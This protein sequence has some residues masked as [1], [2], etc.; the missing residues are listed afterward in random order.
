MSNC[1]RIKQALLGL[2]PSLM[3]TADVVAFE[4]ELEG[5]ASIIAGQVIED[6]RAPGS[7]S[8]PNTIL[9]HTDDVSFTPDSLFAVQLFSDVQDGLTATAQAVAR[10]EEDWEPSLVWGFLTY[11]LHDNV[12][13]KM[14]RSRAPFFL[15]SDTIDVGY[16]YP[17][18]NPPT[19]VYILSGIDNYD[20]IN[21]E[22]SNELASWASRVNLVAGNSA[23]QIRI[24]GRETDIE[25]KQIQSITWNLNRDWFTLQM[26]LAQTDATVDAY[27]QL[28]GAFELLQIPLNEAELDLLTLTDDV[29]TFAGIGV[30]IDQHPWLWVSEYTAIEI[31]DAPMQHDRSAWYS[32]VGYRWQK[33]TS[34]VTY[35]VAK[36]PVA[37]G[38]RAFVNDRIMTRLDLLPTDN[39][40]AMQLI[41][42][43]QLAY[44]TDEHLESIG[45][46]FRYE[47]HRAAAFK[48]EIQHRNNKISDTHPTVM[49]MGIDMVF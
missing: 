48:T 49:L 17:W 8:N 24:G 1:R 23:T 20:G 41:E 14:G 19:D 6:E 13:V 30:Y 2:L 38:T 27:D 26:S 45:L 18:I 37:E 25:C 35:G 21:I 47:F 9:G 7:N 4:A 42:T 34:H 31:E 11:Q 5:F 3:A 39:A 44:L 46:G 28:I 16:S 10:G 32:T 15:F 12:R 36:S 33:L 40:L 43:T 29:T 22:L